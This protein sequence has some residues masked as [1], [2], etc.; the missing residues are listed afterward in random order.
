MKPIEGIR[1]ANAVKCGRKEDSVFHD[2]DVICELIAIKIPVVNGAAGEYTTQPVIR[3]TSKTPEKKVTYT[4]LMNT[5][6]WTWP[7]DVFKD[8]APNT[9]DPTIM[10]AA[11]KRKRTPKDVLI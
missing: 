8:E 5:M 10:Q 1:L 9:L 4:S 11:S 3:M 7:H 6:W 2:T